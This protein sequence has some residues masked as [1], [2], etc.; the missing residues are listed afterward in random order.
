[1]VRLAVIGSF[2]LFALF[3]GA[4]TAPAADVDGSVA[5][6]EGFVLEEREPVE[7]ATK[8]HTAKHHHTTKAAVVGDDSTEED[9]K[10]KKS[11]KSKKTKKSKKGKK[12]KSTGL[13]LTS[14]LSTVTKV[15]PTVVPTILAEEA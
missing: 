10:G 15:V 2:A 7:L 14:I 1:M 13:P 9:K 11:K 5:V 12:T 3:Q 8:T 4:Y 6:G